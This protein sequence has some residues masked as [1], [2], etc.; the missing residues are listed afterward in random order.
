MPIVILKNVRL[1]FPDL[2]KPGRPLNEGDKP[3]YGGQFIMAPDSDAANVAKNALTAAAQEVF[4]A[5]WQAILAAMEKSKKC[6]RRGN[7]NL[8]KDG[9]VRD[10][11]KDMVYVVARNTVKPLLI[12]PRRDP[13]TGEFPVL[14]EADGK[15][16][17]GCFVNAKIDIRAM[18][19]KD[20]IP[21]QV[22]AQLLTVQF[23]ANGESFGAASGTAEGF[24]DVEGAEP[25]TAAAEDLF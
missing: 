2:H 4:G 8:T 6:V 22:F 11:Y 14:S 5:N 16:Y 7:D 3:K 15:P 13:S 18:K 24:D 17:S 1:S 20:K 10:G 25:A 12:G 23:V 19:A 21:N 9:A